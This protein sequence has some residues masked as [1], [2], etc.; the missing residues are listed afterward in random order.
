MPGEQVT[1]SREPS[2]AFSGELFLSLTVLSCR[3]HSDGMNSTFTGNP[4]QRVTV[5]ILCVEKKKCVREYLAVF[6]KHCGTTVNDGFHSD[7]AE[8]NELSVAR[9]MC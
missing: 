2:V 9:G 7:G 4:N 3:W 8:A 6:P 5:K 1:D